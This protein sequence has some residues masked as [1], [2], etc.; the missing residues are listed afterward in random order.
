MELDKQLI[1]NS[2]SI[3][4][5]FFYLNQVDQKVIEIYKLTYKDEKQ[6]LFLA[7]FGKYFNEDII[8]FLIKH[9][10]KLKL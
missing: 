10:L 4:A 7:Y 5:K 8:D 6:V 9:N 3:D 1:Q 2:F